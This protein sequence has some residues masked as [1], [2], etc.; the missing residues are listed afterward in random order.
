MP[1]NFI[2]FVG[3]DNQP[4]FTYSFEEDEAETLHLQMI[5][6]SSLD[7]I[8]ERVEDSK[9]SSNHNSNNT[10]ELFLGQLLVVDGIYHVY[11]LI[12][13]TKNKLIL[14]TSN[15]GEK[16]Y[17]VDSPRVISNSN[18]NSNGNGNGNKTIQGTANSTSSSIKDLILLLHSLYVKDLQNPLQL[19][20][21][22]CSSQ[23][24]TNKIRDVIRHFATSN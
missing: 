17:N 12:S 11:G 7:V 14:I 21:D 19:C 6:N 3:K 16:D 2:A 15:M 5:A 4:V 13:N 18:S 23:S 10:L 8:E 1:V 9:A 22:I 24:F 20:S